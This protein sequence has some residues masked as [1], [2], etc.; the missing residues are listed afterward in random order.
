MRRLDWHGA[1]AFTDVALPDSVCPLDRAALL[2]RF[3]A[4]EDGVILSGAAAFGAL[5]RHMFDQMRKAVFMRLFMPRSAAD[6][7]TH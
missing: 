4:S 1:I 5:E 7:K 3:H 2:A 6:P